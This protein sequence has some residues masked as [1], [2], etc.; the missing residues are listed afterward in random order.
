MTPGS[1]W[2]RVLFYPIGDLHPAGP[3]ASTSWSATPACSTSGSSPSSPSAPTRWRSWA[4]DFGLDFWV[5]LPIAIALSML[6]GP[7]AG[8]PDPAAARRLPGHRHARLRR[9]HPR[10]GQQP[11]VTSAALAASTRSRDR[12]R[13]RASSALTFSVLQRQAVLLPDRASSSWSSSCSSGSSAA[14]SGRSWS[15]I[16]EDED[17]AEL[18]GVPTLTFKLWAFTVGAAVGGSAGVHLRVVPDRDPADRLPVHPL[19]H[20]PG[21]GRAGRGRAHSRCHPRRLPRRAGCRRSPVSSASTAS[22][23][24]V[25]SS[26]L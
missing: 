9:D 14:G 23:S 13:S 1:S 11:G 12:R 5:V 26:S 15:A 19:G 10:H 4:R 7:G 24:S 16:R 6:A 2:E 25:R 21:R 18:M 8:H 22:S 17:A 3:R 20:H